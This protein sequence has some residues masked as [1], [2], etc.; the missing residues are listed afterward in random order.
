MKISQ[1]EGALKSY[2][3]RLYVT[4]DLGYLQ[5]SALKFPRR[6]H[7]PEDI[8]VV[9]FI[10]TCF[11]YGRVEGFTPPVDALLQVLG[12]H[13]YQ[14]ILHF[15]PRRDGDRMRWFYYRFNTAKDLVCLLWFLRQVLERHG[16]L[17]AFYLSG[18][19]DRQE[20]TRAA[21]TTF[22]RRLLPLDPR[23]VFPRG[24]LSSGMHHLLPSP[25]RGGTCKRLHLFLRWM[26][27]RDHIDFGL[28]SELQ[29]AKLIIPLDTHVTQ[30]SRQLG[31]TRL[32]SPGLPMAID[33][34]QNLK[35]LD[36]ADPVKYDFALCRLGMLRNSPK[37]NVRSPKS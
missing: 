7:R 8:E 32:K 9:G 10:A 23:P 4:Y 28:W 34:T 15:D 26:I 30:V 17:R 36:A 33:I 12:P 31:L 5:T 20:D 25:Q 6:Y 21:L 13:P 22:V 29:P 35:R 2:L 24:Q 3:D 11:A 14:S 37:S 1:H 27:R 16:S 19:S 18:Y